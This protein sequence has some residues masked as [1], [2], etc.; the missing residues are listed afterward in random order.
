M[1]Q[2]TNNKNFN[3]QMLL[4][5][6]GENF[7]YLSMMLFALP[8]LLP[9]PYGEIFKFVLGLPLFLI[10]II[11]FFVH[12][13]SYCKKIPVSKSYIISIVKINEEIQNL[14]STIKSI[15]LLPKEISFIQNST[16][17]IITITI[18][19]ILMPYTCHFVFGSISITLYSIS[20]LRKNDLI[21]ILSL[22]LS[23]IYIYLNI[24]VIL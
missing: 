3:L 21:Y 8:F 22:L 13:T 17:Y 15:K 14:T 24:R 18:I 5:I 7:T 4:D 10:A 20:K 23:L 1:K 9:L 12:K 6:M 11:S 19:L 16:K 2:K